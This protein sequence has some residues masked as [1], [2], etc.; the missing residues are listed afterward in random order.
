M[1]NKPKSPE[2]GSSLKRTF[3]A[4]ILATAAGSACTTKAEE[5]VPKIDEMFGHERV[6]IDFFNSSK[7]MTRKEVLARLESVG[8]QPVTLSDIVGPER[9]S[10]ARAG[11]TCED[12]GLVGITIGNERTKLTPE[13]VEALLPETGEDL[14]IKSAYR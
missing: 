2:G 6:E 11:L 12:N 9:A 14:N 13:G 8:L 4:A 3:I 10:A 5:Q 1:I 7:V